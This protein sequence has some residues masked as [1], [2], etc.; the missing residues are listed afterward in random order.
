[1]GLISCVRECLIYP[2]SLELFNREEIRLIY[3]LESSL[4]LQNLKWVGWDT[5]ESRDVHE[6]AITVI[7]TGSDDGLN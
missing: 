4:W 7:R 3:L 5:T 6:Q 1:M 2:K